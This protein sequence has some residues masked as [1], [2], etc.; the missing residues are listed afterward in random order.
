MRKLINYIGIIFLSFIFMISLGQAQESAPSRAVAREG[1][2]SLQEL[3]RMNEMERRLAK[4]ALE[5][6]KEKQRLERESTR[7]EN[8]RLSGLK[9][10]VQPIYR[11]AIRLYNSGELEAAQDQFKQVEWIL[12]DYKETEK[13]LTRLQ[14]DLQEKPKLTQQRQELKRLQAIYEKANGFYE[15]AKQLYAAK[16]YEEAKIQFMEVESVYSDF[17]STRDYLRRI[18][19]TIQKQRDNEENKKVSAFKKSLR[20]EKLTRQ[21]EEEQ[22]ALARYKEQEQLHDKKKE[23]KP[24]SVSKQTTKPPKKEIPKKVEVSKSEPKGPQVDLEKEHLA[25]T[26]AE[27]KQKQKDKKRLQKESERQHQREMKETGKNVEQEKENLQKEQAMI[28]RDFE[29]RLQQLYER[30]VNLYQS[31]LYQ[32][33]RQLFVE[34]DKMQPNYQQTQQYLAKIENIEGLEPRATKSLKRTIDQ[35]LDFIQQKM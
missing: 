6:Q 4:E 19:R 18:Q 34:I 5:N 20:Q 12:P 25:Q 30:A 23:I 31:S 35:T 15:I 9:K 22:E 17:K 16:S 32:E 3:Q 27:E 11:E 26:K 1:G 28:Q 10:Q 24:P 21:D 14:K 13:Y 33:A 8:Q 29:N 7:Q 2:Q